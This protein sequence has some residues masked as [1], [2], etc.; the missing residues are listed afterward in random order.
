MKNYIKPVKS[1]TGC[2]MHAFAIAIYGKEIP[3][4]HNYMKTFAYKISPY[5]GVFAAFALLK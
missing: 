1:T 2:V 4:I 5:I 3:S